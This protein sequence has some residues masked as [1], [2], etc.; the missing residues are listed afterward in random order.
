[1]VL[2]GAEQTASQVDYRVVTQA[3]TVVVGR[4]KPAELAKPE[5]AHLS[6]ILQERA[7]MLLPGEVV[8][9]QPFLRL[10]LAVRFPL[11]PWAVSEEDRGERYTGGGKTGP[12]RPEDFLEKLLE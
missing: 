4:Q 1:V 6:G 9:D 7:A 8:V 12:H 11:T 5:Y 2:L 3:S 10:P